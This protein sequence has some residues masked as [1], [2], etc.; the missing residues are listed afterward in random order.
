MGTSTRL[1]SILDIGPDEMRVGQLMNKVL[2]IADFV[3]DYS[4]GMGLINRIA[5]KYSKNKLQVVHEYVMLRKH[6]AKCEEEVK[7]L[8]KRKGSK[9]RYENKLAVS[10]IEDLKEEISS[11]KKELKMYE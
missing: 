8:Q 3:S 10:E 6:L 1:L 11:I 9:D 4:G 5:S 7:S 2:D